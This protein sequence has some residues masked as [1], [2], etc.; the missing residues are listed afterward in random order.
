MG[1]FIGAAKA[2]AYVPGTAAVPA[3]GGPPG[4]GVAEG[5]PPGWGI[6]LARNWERWVVTEFWLLFLGLFLL[7]LSSLPSLE[8]VA[9]EATRAAGP[10]VVIEVS[11]STLFPLISLGISGG[12]VQIRD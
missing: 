1:A 3:G 9:Q 6:G 12:G 4:R 8:A 11:V 5:S 2:I 7:A 10:A